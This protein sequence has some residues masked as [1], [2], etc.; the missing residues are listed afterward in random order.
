ME[1]AITV[2]AIL[3]AVV[4][5]YILERSAYGR[6]PHVLQILLAGF[7]VWMLVRLVS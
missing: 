3:A 5:M 6:I 7:I 2:F 4:I 1:V